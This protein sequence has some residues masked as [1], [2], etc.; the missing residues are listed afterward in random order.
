MM[1]STRRDRL[2][3][4]MT[5]VCQHEKASVMLRHI[6]LPQFEE[7]TALARQLHLQ[8]Q[9]HLYI[10][11]AIP[12]YSISWEWCREPSSTLRHP[13]PEPGRLTEPPRFWPGL[14]I[15]CH[16]SHWDLCTQCDA[17]GPTAQLSV[18]TL[19]RPGSGGSLWAGLGLAPK[20]TRRVT[21]RVFSV[22]ILKTC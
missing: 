15:L 22:A 19:N 1:Q 4:R 9:L 16:L 10:G 12:H 8:L 3:R 6:L 20:K 17:C 11:W 14:Y 2:W 21:R 7:C 13:P 18:K 5:C